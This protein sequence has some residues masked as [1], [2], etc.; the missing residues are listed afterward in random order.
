MHEQM[1]T[2]NHARPAPTGDTCA[3]GADALPPAARGAV[4]MGFRGCC[5]RG[6]VAEAPPG[7]AAAAAP[8][9]RN[10]GLTAGVAALGPPAGWA[11]AGALVDGGRGRV[12]SPPPFRG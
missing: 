1:I 4:I 2:P 8:S 10:V 5:L 7:V 12:G 6:G 9:T 11:V 3:G